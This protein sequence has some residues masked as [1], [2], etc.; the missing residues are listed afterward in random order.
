[1]NESLVP[2]DEKYVADLLEIYTLE[3]AIEGLRGMELAQHRGAVRRGVVPEV[4]DFV[5]RSGRRRRR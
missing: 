2:W 5:L 4:S 3:Q 1:M